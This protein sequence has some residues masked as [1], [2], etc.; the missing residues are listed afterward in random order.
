M[1]YI[2][3]I[4]IRP[5]LG[6]DI[7]R[8]G[9]LGF[10]AGLP[11]LL[12]FSTMSVWL[13][14][15]GVER[16]TITLFSWAGFAYSFKFLWSP[17][18]D[19]Y[20]FPLKKIGKRKSWLY[21]TQIFIL[22]S[23][24]FTSFTDPSKNLYWTAIGVVLIAFGSASQ[25]IIIDAFRIESAPEKTQGILSSVY[26][27][28]YRI[29]MVVS[30]AGS[31]WL[32]SFMGVKT[33]DVNTW[34]YV[35][36][37]MSLF[38]L[39]GICATYFSS[40]PKIKLKT[41][42]NQDQQKN[43]LFFILL[44]IFIFFIVLLNLPDLNY[45]NKV[46]NFLYSIFKIL[47]SFGTVYLLNLILKK[48]NLVTTSK[49]FQPYLDPFLDFIK[50]YKK[51]AF[52]ILILISLYRI[53]DIVMGVV[54]NIFYLEKGYDVSEIATF[55]KFFG[56]FATILGGFLGGISCLR[57]GTSKSLFWGAALAALTNVLFAYV[58]ISNKNLYLLASVIITDNI[59]GG[60]AG[61]AF[62]VY[63]S[64]LTSLKF[65]ATQYALFSSLMLFIPKFI[66]GY[67]GSLVTEIGYP[68]FFI[69]SAILG[70]PVLFLIK[71]LEKTMIRNS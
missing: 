51:T 28:G 27:A 32:A 60:F 30:G 65:T 21:F 18:M 33:Y 9:M 49:G 45:T 24:I 63:L 71:Y 43:F 55:S 68:A 50:R 22:L 57:W 5:F 13:F 2:I 19:R 39:L 46:F 52:I 56:L 15:A 8:M 4:Y 1:I 35:Y 14:H 67:S 41:V 48:I 3:N 58:A 17:I 34:K 23:I 44:S 54:A 12:I 6:F 7:L 26:L 70:I 42:I 36:Q 29:A 64:S 25:D 10:S 66:S 40:E 69:F 62:V 59:A 37:I 53:A 11:L 31:L 47:F 61:A 16:S 38:M 20:Q